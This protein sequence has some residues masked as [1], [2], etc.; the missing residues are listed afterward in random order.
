MRWTDYDSK[1]CSVARTAD[2]IGDRWTVLV[3]RDLFN[4]IRRFDDLTAHLGIARDILSRR[5][6]ALVEAGVVE[7][8]PYQE[9]G[10]RTR[11]EYRL[12]EAGAEL[13]P[14]MV[15][16]AQWGDA[17]RAGADGPPTVVLHRACGARVH[18]ALVC[19]RGHDILDGAQVVM[20]PTA[21][22]RL[23]AHV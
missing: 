11:F 5:L 1:V 8:Q 20:R 10:H 6:S 13:R 9:A 3:L 15:A 22:A 16:M 7:R 14:V 23:I 17:H 2:V 18:A 19:D 4:G 21:A 12:T